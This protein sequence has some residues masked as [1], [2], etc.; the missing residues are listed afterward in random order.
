MGHVI[1]AICA[2][3]VIYDIYAVF[4]PRILHVTYMLY[5]VCMGRVLFRCSPLGY[6]VYAIYAI[7][8][9][10]TTVPTDR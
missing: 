1:Y 2:K 10:A 6:P 7:Y 5:M 8:A 3:R 9:S 4:G